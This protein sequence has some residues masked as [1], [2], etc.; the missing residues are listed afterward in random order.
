MLLHTVCSCA[1][2][3][4]IF[5]AKYG[6]WYACNDCDQIVMVRKNRPYTLG[7]WHE[8]IKFEMHITAVART[9]RAKVL[10][11]LKK[12][13]AGKPISRWDEAELKH[14]STKQKGIMQFAQKKT[15]STISSSAIT[16]TSKSVE[17]TTQPSSKP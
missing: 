2:H 9:E 5:T 10:K 13:S 12:K 8:H 15:A 1:S 16:V 17:S 14:T 4:Q 6:L 3:K 7:R 11:I